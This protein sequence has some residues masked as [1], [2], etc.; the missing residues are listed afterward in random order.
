MVLDA[1]KL[2]EFDHPHIL[3]RNRVGF[4]YKM[5]GETGRSMATLLHKMAAE[6]KFNP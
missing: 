1:G 4:F 2:V 6:V 5:V 3:L